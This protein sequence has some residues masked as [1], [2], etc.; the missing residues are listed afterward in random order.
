M[1][2]ATITTAISTEL[3]ALEFHLEDENTQTFYSNPS[4][5]LLLFM[6]DCHTV[7]NQRSKE[8]SANMSLDTENTFRVI[9]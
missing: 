6:S 5:L 2:T 9:I 7:P 4:F 8:G 1:S 3:N